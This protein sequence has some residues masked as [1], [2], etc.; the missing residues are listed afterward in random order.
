MQ[1]KGDIYLHADTH[2]AATHIVKNHTTE[3]VPP[4]TLAQV[5]LPLSYLI[6][7]IYCIVL[8]SHPPHTTVN[9]ICLVIVNNK[10][11]TFRGS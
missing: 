3:T 9:L 7:C 8:E 5:P 6:Q 2:G 1:N 11:T 4:L 10:L